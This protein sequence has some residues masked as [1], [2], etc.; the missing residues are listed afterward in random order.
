MGLNDLSWMQH[1]CRHQASRLIGAGG[2][3][4]ILHPFTCGNDSRHTVLF[5]IIE[6][7]RRWLVCPDCDYRQ[8]SG[9]ADRKEQNHA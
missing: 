2:E 6:D 9:E 5:P 1:V 3:F 4:A 8:D 7:G